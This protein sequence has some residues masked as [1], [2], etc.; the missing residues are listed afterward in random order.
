MSRARRKIF[1]GTGLI[2]LGLTLM[3][4][5]TY[6]RV[7]GP[8]WNP[9]ALLG[10]GERDHIAG[11]VC[12]IQDEQGRIISQ[13]GRRV[14]V[15]DEIITA[16]GNHYRVVRVEGNTARARFLGLDR[17]LLAYNEFYSQM[18]VPVSRVAR[19][20]QPV[21]IYHTHSDESYVPS[22]GSE[23]IPFHG[24]IYQVGQSLVD[25]LQKK[26]TRVDYDKTP[27]DPHDDNAYYRSRRT[28]AN[29]MKNNPIALFDVHRDGIPDPGY[30]RKNI[31]QEDVAQTRLVIGRENPRMQANLDF[32]KRLMSYANSVHKP[33][34]KEIFMGQG[35]YN[36]D[37]MPTAVLIE[38]GT[39][40]NTREEAERGIA[41]LADAVPV[42]LG[43][44][45]PAPPGA[46]KPVTDR[47]AATPGS[48][49]A[50]AWI[51][52]L[53]VLGSGAFL[54]ISAGGWD[55]ASARLAHFFGREFASFLGP[56]RERKALDASEKATV[57]GKRDPDASEADRD[58][59]SRIRQD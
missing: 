49:N 52:I 50:L 15:N 4:L 2:I 10:E 43:I 3:A 31:S 58:H 28:A 46:P 35:N 29:L 12:T 56:R 6:S 48:W 41:L 30:Y 34:V 38:A 21:G 51:I 33:I 24:G 7:S 45:A 42:I 23:A 9:R 37:L 22:D 57:P 20:T 32:A 18:T 1:W 40:T 36:Q 13:V 14:S 47:T 27:H 16:D 11:Y 8:V 44:T 19:T 17:D 59:L 25:R 26:G 5:Y 53:T 54:V 55:R 39:H